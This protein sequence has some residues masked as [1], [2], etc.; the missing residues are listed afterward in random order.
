MFAINPTPHAAFSRFL[1]KSDLDLIETFSLL[2]RIILSRLL[3]VVLCLYLF[4]LSLSFS[5]Y[6][7]WPKFNII[8]FKV[9][10]CGNVSSA[11]MCVCVCVCVCVW[12]LD[13]WRDYIL[14]ATTTL[15]LRK[16]NVAVVGAERVGASRYARDLGFWCGRAGRRAG[17]GWML[18]VAVIEGVV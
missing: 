14:T 5:L 9:S 1:S 18:V 7:K 8:K 3:V 15:R 4:S 10:L 13:I 11:G 2:A 16:Y 17:V 12:V 6:R